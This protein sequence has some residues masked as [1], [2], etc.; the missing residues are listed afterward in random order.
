MRL[1]CFFVL[2]SSKRFGFLNKHWLSYIS[3][4]ESLKADFKQYDNPD[5]YE[6]ILENNPEIQK[7]KKAA[8]LIP[9][10]FKNE[11]T[12]FTLSK[13]TDKMNSFSGDVS[14]LGGK[15]DKTDK[16]N[17]YTAFREAYEEAGIESKDLTYLAQLCPIIT[18]NRI[19]V[20]PVI[21]YF[22]KKNY[23]PKLNS[24]EVEMLFELPTERF[25]NEKGHSTETYETDHGNYLVHHFNDIINE[26]VLDTWGYTAFM[27]IVVSKL[28]HKRTAS[29]TL[30]PDITFQHNKINQDLENFLYK[31][32]EYSKKM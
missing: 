12:Y 31:K 20:T 18:F 30:V 14:F 7:L 22:N 25:L 27:C 32:L 2:K 29:F 3:N 5:I 23:I 19:L 11:Q 10:S 4:E 21:C 28:I 1:K 8:V 17:I 6:K 16:N 24:N 26:K 15:Q 13:R 9:I